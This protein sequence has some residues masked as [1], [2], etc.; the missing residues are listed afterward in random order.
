[1]KKKPLDNEIIRLYE[2]DFKTKQIAERLN[3]TPRYVSNRI[4]TLRNNGF[5]IKRWWEDKLYE[6]K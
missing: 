1:M 3:L 6:I 5:I 4:K 2:N